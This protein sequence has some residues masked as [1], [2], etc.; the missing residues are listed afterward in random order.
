MRFRGVMEKCSFCIQRV[1]GAQ[2]RAGLEERALGS[3]EVVTAC[4]QACPA[5]AIIFG[6]LNNPNSE[7]SKQKH[8][9]R[10]YTMLAELNIKPRVSYLARVQNANSSL[11]QS[12]A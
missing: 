4:Q 1:R 9:S 2:K 3:G 12:E 10:N 6:D 5:Q 8:N 11:E 7:V